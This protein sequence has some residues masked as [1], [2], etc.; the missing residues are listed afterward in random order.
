[1]PMACVGGRDSAHGRGEPR[2]GSVRHGRLKLVRE[3]SD[4]ADVVRGD[5]TACRTQR[6]RSV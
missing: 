3:D 5:D 2:T 1:M 6:R 4:A